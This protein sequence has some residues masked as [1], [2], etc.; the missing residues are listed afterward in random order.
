MNAAER[1]R[2]LV[3]T[4]LAAAAAL[5]AQQTV[6]PTEARVGPVRG[7]NIGNYNVVNSFETGYR[8]RRIDGNEGKYRSDIN[9]GN[10][11]RLLGSSL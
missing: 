11:L 7:D 10:G 6:T 3:L 5:A 2:D 1:I 4:A 9:Y 8:F